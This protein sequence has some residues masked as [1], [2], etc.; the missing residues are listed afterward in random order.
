MSDENRPAPGQARN[1][2]SRYT[3]WSELLTHVLDDMT[4]IADLEARLLEVQLLNALDVAMDRALHQWVSGLLWLIGGLCL[5]SALIVLL[6][7]WF[8]LWQSLALGGA[9]AIVAGLAVW[10]PM[11]RK[12]GKIAQPRKEAQL[13]LFR[14]S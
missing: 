9:V 10:L 13:P 3:D 6:Q 4:R 12:A 5:L 1:R 11:L 2:V 8:P 14:D 7:K